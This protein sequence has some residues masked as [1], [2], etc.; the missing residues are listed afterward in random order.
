VTRLVASF[1]VATLVAATA[2]AQE[3]RGRTVSIA[4]LA[5]GGLAVVDP[6]TGQ[7]LRRV[8]GLTQATFGV[9]VNPANAA[10]AWA[11]G[12]TSGQLFELDLRRWE[13]TGEPVALSGAAGTAVASHQPVMTRDGRLVLVTTPGDSSLTIIDTRTRAVS[14]LPLNHD[15]HIVDIDPATGHVFVSRRGNASGP[16]RGATFLDLERLRAAVDLSAGVQVTPD[17]VN[18][19]KQQGAYIEVPINGTPRV[20]SALG[21]GRFAVAMYGKRGPLVYQVRDGE[22]TLLDDLD[23]MTSHG[24]GPKENM[25]YL[26]MAVGSADGRTLVGTD[27][28][29]P[30]SLRVWDLDPATGRGVRERRAIPLPAEPYWVN[31]SADG[32][33]AYVSLP[34]RKDAQGADITGG[35]VTI[36]VTSGR[37]VNEVA[38]GDDGKVH[39]PKR[40]I[41][42]ELPADIVAAA[43]RRPGMTDALQGVGGR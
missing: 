15:P 4:A 28:G 22:A 26:E 19:L 17:Q 43:E 24:G 10:Q 11:V 34:K 13:V 9:V 40:M 16:S 2:Q 20:I 5:D 14:K 35:V 1:L 8:D 33:T 36:D 25:E 42:L 3:A 18:Q 27:Q 23:N 31:L 12:E 21:N 29:V 32:R 6:A 30:S 38:I 37:I 7:L 39:T 41:T